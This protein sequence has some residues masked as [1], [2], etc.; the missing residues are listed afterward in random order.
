MISSVMVYE[1]NM[2]QYKGKSMTWIIR[3]TADELGMKKDD[4]C[5]VLDDYYTEHEE[6]PEN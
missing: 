2:Y 4:L 1:K 6:C 5:E 3:I